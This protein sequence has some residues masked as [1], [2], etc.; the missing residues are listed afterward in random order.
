MTKNETRNRFWN[1]RT[2]KVHK[3]EACAFRWGRNVGHVAL[4]KASE[5]A[6]LPQCG[7]CHKESRRNE[8]PAKAERPSCRL[9]GEYNGSK[10]SDLCSGCRDSIEYLYGG[11][12]EAYIEQNKVNGSLARNRRSNGLPPLA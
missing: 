2:N 9:C 1:V 4:V 11:S 12:E 10:K 7:Q 5:V 6:D 8:K 3:S